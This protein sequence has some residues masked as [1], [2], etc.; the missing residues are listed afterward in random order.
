MCENKTT[1]KGQLEERF[2][3]E[4]HETK[5]IRG[6][7][8]TYIPWAHVCQRLNDV[9]GECW[10]WE[11]VEFRT[12][13]TQA[14]VLGKLTV[15]RSMERCKMAFGGSEPQKEIRD[16]ADA[17][18]SAQSDALRKAAS[19]LGVGLYLWKGESSSPRVE[20]SSGPATNGGPYA[21]A[22][23]RQK[24][25]LVAIA[26]HVKEWTVDDLRSH[27]METF[28][29]PDELSKIDASTLIDSL[30]RE[31]E[32]NLSRPRD[33]GAKRITER[34]L[35]MIMGIA[36]NLELAMPDLMAQTRE[37]L[38]RSEGTLPDL[39]SLTS[40]EASNVITILQKSA[41]HS[42]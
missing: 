14:F 41:S 12:T 7:E 8:L 28:G 29:N 22:T 33:D 3:A 10:S 5:T 40:Q 1:V 26:Q 20:P 36:R 2:Q 25:A 16:L 27:I 4:L 38:N 11:V 6:R 35:N 32:A 19:L 30:K 21:L 9:Y 37:M 18:K 13:T 24:K 42:A 15:G 23:A 39:Q 17:L 31:R 34:Q